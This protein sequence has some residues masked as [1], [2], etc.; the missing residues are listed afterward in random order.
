[1]TNARTAKTTREKAAELRQEAERKA[2]R[3]RTLIVGALVVVVLAIV[4]TAVV[5]IRNHQRDQDLKTA[6]AAAPPANLYTAPGAAA[7]GVLVGQP[8]AKVT[9]DLYEDFQCPVCAQFEQADGELLRGYATAGKIKL[10]YHSVAFLNNQ[11]TTEYSTRAAVAAA[12]VLN[13]T[14]TAWN[15]YHQSLFA[16]QPAEGS[17]GLPDSQLVDLAVAAGAPKDTVA[18]ALSGGLFKGW[19]ANVTDEFLKKYNGTPTVLL[20]GTQLKNLEPT[21]LKTEVDKAVAAAG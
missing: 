1:M 8:S 3:K 13:S 21:A 19:V 2:A 17:A 10:V 18:G 11:S 9:V 12:A 16:N 7:A 15:A 20:N 4:V 5:L 6:K 14:P